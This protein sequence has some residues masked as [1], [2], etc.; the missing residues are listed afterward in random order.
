VHEVLLGDGC[1]AIGADMNV[2]LERGDDTNEATW[3]L[4][5]PG[6]DRV[7]TIVEW[8]WMGNA[9]SS[10]GS[11]GARRV[12]Y[13]SSLWRIRKEVLSGVHAQARRSIRD[14]PDQT[15]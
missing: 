10:F 3:W 13:M 5:A 8:H 15:A 2:W 4:E 9:P 11:H 14:Q 7:C 6:S 12:D 1:D